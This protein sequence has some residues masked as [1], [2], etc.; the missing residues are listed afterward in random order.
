MMADNSSSGLLSLRGEAGS[1]ALSLADHLGPFLA[2]G[3][4]V[5]VAREDL[6]GCPPHDGGRI[7]GALE[8]LYELLFELFDICH[9][10]CVG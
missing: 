3:D 4:A 7:L 5:S 2:G 1:S 6:L 10:R 8:L 9:V